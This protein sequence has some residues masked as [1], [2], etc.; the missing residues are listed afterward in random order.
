MGL[1]SR[2]ILSQGTKCGTLVFGV[3]NATPTGA[4]QNKELH[5][6]HGQSAGMLEGLTFVHKSI[7]HIHSALHTN[8][9]NER[10]TLHHVTKTNETLNS[11][12]QSAMGHDNL[13]PGICYHR[14]PK[15]QHQR[16]L[17]LQLRLQYYNDCYNDYNEY[18]RLQRIP[19]TTMTKTTTTRHKLRRLPTPSLKIKPLISNSAPYPK[20]NPPQPLF[21]SLLNLFGPFQLVQSS[22]YPAPQTWV[23]NHSTPTPPSDPVCRMGFCAEPRLEPNSRM[24]FRA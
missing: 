2:P 24:G 10:R 22:P 13:H 23:E 5:D 8:R 4:N 7:H 1:A 12:I 18:Q 6:W 17:R 3:L 15:L 16:L 20:P 9:H 19:T 21:H 14:A 11:N